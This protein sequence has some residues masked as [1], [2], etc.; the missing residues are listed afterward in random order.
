[1][2]NE[3]PSNFDYSK[4]EEFLTRIDNLEAE[5]EV[6][7]QKANDEKAPIYEAIKEVKT[8]AHD[9]GFRRQPFNAVMADRKAIRKINARRAKLGE[10]QQ[11]EYDRIKHSLGMLE[12]LPLFK[13]ADD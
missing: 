9:A 3:V 7:E 13:A 10:D 1:M 8:E 6:I 11:D 12:E 2:P 5:I 4:A